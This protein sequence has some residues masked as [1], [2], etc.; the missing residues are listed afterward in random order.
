M[1][2]L[3][4]S[5]FLFLVSCSTVHVK[6]I[7][8]PGRVGDCLFIR[9]KYSMRQCYSRARKEC[10]HG[11]KIIYSSNVHVGGATIQR[12]PSTLIVKCK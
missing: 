5:L 11:F 8:V 10:E 2:I 1:R 6:H 9:C 3:V 12:H 7:V 4:A